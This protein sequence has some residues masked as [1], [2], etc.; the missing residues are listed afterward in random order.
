MRMFAQCYCC[1]AYNLV[2]EKVGQVIF[3]KRCGVQVDTCIRNLVSG[4][5]CSSLAENGTLEKVGGS[6]PLTPHTPH[7]SAI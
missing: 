2:Y 1:S 3:C 5:S 6:L 7:N 4:T